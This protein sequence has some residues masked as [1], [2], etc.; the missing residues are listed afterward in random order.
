MESLRNAGHPIA[1]LVTRYGSSKSA[2]ILASLA[3]FVA[4][5]AGERVDSADAS[6]AFLLAEKLKGVE[7]PTVLQLCLNAL[8][9]EIILSECAKAILPPAASELVVRALELSGDQA[10]VVYTTG[11]DLLQALCS[12]DTLQRSFSESQMESLRSAVAR[13]R[14]L[15]N[16]D[17]REDA[18]SVLECLGT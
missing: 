16:V 5:H 13:I 2:Y 18:E 14:D 11:L 12:R 8:H 9:G 3:F 7:Q 17:L 6:P 4:R 1:E 15:K 10:W